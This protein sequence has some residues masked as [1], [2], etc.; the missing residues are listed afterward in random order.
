MT[1]NT[2]ALAAL[3]TPYSVIID[4]REQSPYAFVG[5]HADARQGGRPLSIPLV[6]RTLRSGDYSLEGHENEVAV[7][8]KSL[9]DFFNT[10]GQGR[11]RFERELDRLDEM[12]THGAAFVVVEASWHTILTS[13]PERSQLRP[14]V[15]YRSVIA[16]QQRFVRVHWWMVEGRRLAEVTTLRI[17]ERFWRDR[18]R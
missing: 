6:M 10:I 7:E 17:L 11:K 12:A 16:W 9:A 8:R 14:K 18:H 15:V 5:L 3:V 13:P 2:M 1:V 4:T